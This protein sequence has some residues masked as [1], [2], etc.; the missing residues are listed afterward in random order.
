MKTGW[1][2]ALLLLSLGV[3]LGVALVVV[4]QLLRGPAD[5]PAA[6]A[7]QSDPA[8]VS[9]DPAATSDLPDPASIPPDAASSA[10]DAPAATD[11]VTIGDVRVDGRA[12][13]VDVPPRR[14]MRGVERVADRLGLEGTA[15]ERFL[16]LQVTLFR[17][18]TAARVAAR[19]ERETLRQLL[20]A[21]VPDVAAIDAQLATLAATQIGVERAFAAHIVAVREVLTPEQL[22]PYL[23]FVHSVHARRK[24]KRPGAEPGVAPGERVREWRRR[25]AAQQRLRDG[26]R[27]PPR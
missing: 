18:T 6:A 27:P 19:A 26:D 13:A 23:R 12:P 11:G 15:R 5:A 1:L 3:N 14:L 7:A 2:A 21:E 17:D 20:L 25:R 8:A 16:A 10:L 24:G 9:P 4:P 22:P